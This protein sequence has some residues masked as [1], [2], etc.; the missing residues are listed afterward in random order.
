[1]RG[2]VGVLRSLNTTLYAMVASHFFSSVRGG[3][4]IA[5]NIFWI[6]CIPS[7]GVL[8]ATTPFVIKLLLCLLPPT[9]FTFGIVSIVDAGA[10]MRASLRCSGVW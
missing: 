1:M 3:T 8:H 5:V 10:Y 6:M 2:D 9:S 7:F 4:V